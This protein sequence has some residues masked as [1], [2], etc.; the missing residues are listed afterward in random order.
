MN[1]YTIHINRE[2][3]NLN[4]K[5]LLLLD[6]ITGVLVSS[7]LYNRTFF[8]K[9]NYSSFFFNNPTKTTKKYYLKVKTKDQWLNHT[10]LLK[11]SVPFTILLLYIYDKSKN[12]FKLG[13]ETKTYNNLIFGSFATF[14]SIIFI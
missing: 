9:K 4:I 5:D 2:Q 14:F 7:F 10:L 8:K 6:W 13:D 12:L 1:D 11:Q 3:K